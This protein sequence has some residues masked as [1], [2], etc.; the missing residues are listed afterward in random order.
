[1]TSKKWCIMFISSVILTCFLYAMFNILIDPFGV[2][3]DKIYDWYSYNMTNNPRVA[4]TVYLD[5]HYEEYV[6]W[7]LA[8]HNKHY[9]N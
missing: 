3:G 7:K 2:F 8:L 1:M 6:L 9:E 5:E 4:K